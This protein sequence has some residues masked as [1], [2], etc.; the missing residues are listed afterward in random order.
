MAKQLC[1]SKLFS[2]NSKSYLSKAISEVHDVIMYTQKQKHG[3]TVTNYIIT[4][5]PDFCVM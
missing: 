4:C 3:A 2:K 1:D 5:K